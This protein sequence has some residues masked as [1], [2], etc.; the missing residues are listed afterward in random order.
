MAVSF[1]LDRR[2]S[3]HCGVGACR[4]SLGQQP[5]RQDEPR[6][7]YRLPL[8]HPEHGLGGPPERNDQQV[9]EDRPGSSF[10]DTT[11]PQQN[12]N[13]KIQLL[14]SQNALP[15]LYNTPAVDSVFQMNKRAG[16]ATSARS[17]RSSAS[18]TISF[19]LRLR[20]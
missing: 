5:H 7:S 14:A 17:S 8:D 4:G 2:R 1:C 20:F 19:R 16:R 12:L 9:Q 3:R 18:L 15:M 11:V 13:Q 6:R 10:N